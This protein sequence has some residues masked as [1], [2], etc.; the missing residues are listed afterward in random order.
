M[1]DFK[2]IL[3]IRLGALGDILLCMKPFQDIRNGHRD[4]RITLLTMPSFAGFAR[5]M[6]WFDHVIEDTR[7]QWWQLTAWKSLKNSIQ[8][9][10][11]D[12]VIDLQNKPRSRFYQRAFFT[13]GVPWSSSMRNSTFPHISFSH[14]M[15]RQE[16][17]LVQLRATGTGD[18]GALNL[19]W[20]AAPSEALQLPERYVVLVPGCSPHLLHKRWPATHYAKLAHSLKTMGFEVVVV[21][22]AADAAPIADIKNQADFIIDISGRTHF[23]QLAS[24]YRN[25]SAVVGNDTGPTFLAAM[26]GAPTLTLMSHHTDPVRSGPVGRR[27]AWI[28]ENTIAHISVDAVRNALNTL[29]H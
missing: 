20:L 9:Q 10:N 12:C 6:P 28:K 19:D 1:S 29:F 26:V 11:F 4:A 14:K 2:N 3:V 21:G 7:P 15:H 8:S 17:L 23:A 27:C 5:Q 13:R 18:S 16:E 24:V 22:T 25:A